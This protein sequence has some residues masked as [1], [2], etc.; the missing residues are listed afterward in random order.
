MTMT[1]EATD[2]VTSQTVEIEVKAQTITTSMGWMWGADD[3]GF[4]GG[5]DFGYQSPSSP[6]TTITDPFGD[7]T[8]EAYQDAED[9]ADKLGETALPL[10]TLLKIGFLF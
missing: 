1:A 2:T 10:F 6:E 5:M 9:Q 7:T 4:Y 8:S 3:G